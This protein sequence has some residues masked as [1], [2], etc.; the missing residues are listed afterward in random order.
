VLLIGAIAG[1]FVLVINALGQWW[2]HQ[3]AREAKAQRIEI[4]HTAQATA[5]VADRKLDVIHDLTN[6]NMTALKAQL[7]A[8]L[9]RIDKLENLLVERR[10]AQP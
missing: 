8:A 5:E 6:S 3:D 9:A 4:A 7:A 1:G 10:T 2:G